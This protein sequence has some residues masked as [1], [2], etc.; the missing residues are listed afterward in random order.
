VSAEAPEF[1]DGER[2]SWTAAVRERA[3]SALPPKKLLADR[4]P[5]YVSS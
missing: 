2:R 3:V 4:Q 1:N 5:S